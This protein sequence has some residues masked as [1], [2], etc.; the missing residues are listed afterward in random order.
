MSDKKKLV[1]EEGSVRQF[2]KIA[3]LGK[4][5]E[6][7]IKK[8]VLKEGESS[9]RGRTFDPHG[10]DARHDNLNEETDESQDL[11]ESEVTEEGTDLDEEIQEEGEVQEEAVGSIVAKGPGKAIESG[12]GMNGSGK[13]V[14]KKMQ[15]ESQSGLTPKGPGKA[16]E[17]GKGLSASGK[18]PTKKI[19]YEATEEDGEQIAEGFGEEPTDD[20]GGGE[21]MAPAP[22]MGGEEAPP[23]TGD[24]QGLVKAIADAISAHTGVSVS[25]E[26]GE[27][28]MGGGEEMPPPDMGGEEVPTEEEPPVPMQEGKRVQKKTSKVSKQ[29]KDQL[30]DAITRNVLAK[31]SKKK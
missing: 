11:D 14:S 12:K 31:L 21:E 23:A 8:K 27:S 24:L 9:G 7:F 19:Q 15:Y 6:G 1:L 16:I 18:K 5:S 3:G 28:D 29:Q 22:D 13:K 4:L 17:S 30:V 10:D 25:V 2:M 20:L 26:G